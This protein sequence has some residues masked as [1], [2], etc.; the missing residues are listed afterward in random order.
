[1]KK[2]NLLIIKNLII[3]NTIKFK[4]SR[5][6]ADQI[7]SWRST[8]LKFYCIKL[9]FSCMHFSSL[10]KKFIAKLKLIYIFIQTKWSN[11]EVFII[12]IN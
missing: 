5:Y 8:L 11:W 4:Q 12:N 2:Y 7:W 10:Q 6:S 1:M 9:L 3:L